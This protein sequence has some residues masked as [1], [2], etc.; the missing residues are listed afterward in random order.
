MN[1][2]Q[3]YLEIDNFDILLFKKIIKQSLFVS[4]ELILEF[5]NDSVKSCSF[6]KTKSLI[7]LWGT[8][9]T[10]FIKC[11]ENSLDLLEDPKNNIKFIGEEFDLFN[12]YVLKGEYL[13]KFLDVF[14]INHH[15][16]LRI[17]HTDGKASHIEIFGYTA[18]DSK[19]KS[20]FDL[21]TEEFI[22]NKVS[23]FK[24]ILREV[25]PTKDLHEIKINQNTIF[26]IK[27]LIKNLHKSM[28]N[29]TTFITFTFDDNGKLS[30]NDKVFNLDVVYES[31]EPVPN[32]SFNM[33]KS[34]FM[35]IGEHNFS[36]FTNENSPKIIFNA[37][38]NNI[39]ISCMSTKIA[40][41]INNDDFD[42]NDIDSFSDNL[43]LEE[44][45]L[46]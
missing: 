40:D 24:Q 42:A 8:P 10:T 35:L 11:D 45:G 22:T 19:I 25:T 14:S 23:D 18:N 43:N 6:S 34:D 15:S 39:I 9:Y 26:E 31:T 30:I 3:Q 27:S 13:L 1:N 7:K 12:F 2:N 5:N 41:D 38:F 44:Y 21:T 36:I 4:N 37:L 46:S 33:L 20:K 16:K 28:V 29:N 17:Y 32:F